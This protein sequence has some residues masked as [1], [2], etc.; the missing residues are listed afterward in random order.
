MRVTQNSIVEQ[1]QFNLQRLQEQITRTNLHISTGKAFVSPAEAPLRAVDVKHVE[2][3]IQQNLRYKTNI[4]KGITELD[5]YEFA[6]ENFSANLRK[7]K[8]IAEAALSPVNYDKPKVLGEQIRRI[9]DDLIEIANY[10]HNGR[11]LFAGTLTTKDAITPTAP[12]TTRLPFELVTDPTAATTNNPEGLQVHFK[13]NFK[14]RSVQVSANVQERINSLANDAFGDNGTRVFEILVD[15]YNTLTYQRDGTERSDTG[16]L[17]VQDAR[18]L[19]SLITQLAD[20]L[21]LLHKENGRVGGVRLRLETQLRQITYENTRLNELK[22]IR[23]DADIAKE[24]INLTRFQ[25]SLG[26]TL[27]VGARLLQTTLFDF[28]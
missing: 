7:A 20:H 24:A 11:F 25:T 13:G 15:I 17:D 21:D 6:L 10:Q 22:S 4:E 14:A 8:S 9:L 12:A 3:R 26:Y 2:T 16:T 18:R 28:L 5:I 19:Q 23:G 27:Q 1:Y